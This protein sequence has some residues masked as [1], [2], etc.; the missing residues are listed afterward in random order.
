MKD[1]GS[2]LAEHAPD[3]AEDARE[4]IEKAVKANYKTVSEWEKKTARIA[5]LEEQVQSLSAQVA[6]T[7][8]AAERIEAM[9]KALD[10]YEAAEA[11]R[12]AEEAEAASREAFASQFD[13]AI[14]GKRFANEIIRQSVFDR[15]YEKCA[16]EKGLG[17]KDAID[18]IV[19]GEHGIWA[20]PQRDPHMMPG[21]DQLTQ[22]PSAEDAKR[23]FAASLFG[24]K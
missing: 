10:A 9:Q 16:A 18:S 8:D 15:A 5:S 1:I 23:T 19:E 7:G 17:A 4:A 13:A 11:Q 12:K 20:N 14:E 3:M 6:D 2:I 21:K 22:K 24:F